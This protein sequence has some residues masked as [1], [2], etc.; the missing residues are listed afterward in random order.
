MDKNN[1]NLESEQEDPL[2]NIKTLDKHNFCN[3]N[4]KNIKLRKKIELK[5]DTKVLKIDKKTFNEFLKW[6]KKKNGGC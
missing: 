6:F 4:L 3:I 5:K 2:K 1:E